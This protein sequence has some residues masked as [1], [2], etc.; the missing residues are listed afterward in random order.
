MIVSMMSGEDDGEH[1]DH[2]QV[3]KSE[4]RIPIFWKHFSDF[5]VSFKYD[6]QV[7]RSVQ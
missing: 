4:K 5:V 7:P 3:G 1:G 2:Q 6:D